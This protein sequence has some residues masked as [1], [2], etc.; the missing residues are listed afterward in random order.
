MAYWSF[1]LSDGALRMLVLLHFHALGFSPLSLATLFL[2]YELCGVMTTLMGGWI[3][4]RFGLKLTLLLGLALQVASLLMLSRL[5]LHWATTYQ[6][7]FVF[8]AQG[9]SGIAKDFTKISA[10][11]S[12]RVLLPQ[13]SDASGGQLFRWVA[14]LTGS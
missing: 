14:L 6:V 8:L 3:G 10:K 12:L 11:S 1:T 2:L 9:L 13:E 7:G 5:D 4:T